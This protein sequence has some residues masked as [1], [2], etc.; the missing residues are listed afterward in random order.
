MES[1]VW[2]GSEWGWRPFPDP[3]SSSS[4]TAKCGRVAAVAVEDSAYSS[5]IRQDLDRDTVENEHEKDQQHTG[6]DN[7]TQD[8]THTL[9]G[10]GFYTGMVVQ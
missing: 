3:S 10:D 5:S 4:D 9:F 7:L 8:D 6:E 2:Q 1:N